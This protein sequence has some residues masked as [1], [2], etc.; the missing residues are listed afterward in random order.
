MTL[1]IRGTRWKG[2]SM[3]EGHLFPSPNAVCD[4]GDLDCGN[5]LLL[6]IRKAIDPLEPGQVLEVRSRE[7]SVEGDLPA[8]CRMVAHDFL[9][10]A[11]GSRY[12]SYFIRKGGA[13]QRP[14]AG[15]RAPT[16]KQAALTAA[17]NLGDGEEKIG[18]SAADGLEGTL[19]ED[20]EKARRFTWAVRAR[21]VDK[22]QSRVYARGQSFTVG[23]PIDFDFSKPDAPLSAVEYLLASLAACLTSGYQVHASRRGVTV[24]EAELA[25]RGGLNNPLIYLGLEGEGHSGFSEINGTFYVNADG[26]EDTLTELWETTLARSPIVA[27]L[28]NQVKLNLRFS[29]VL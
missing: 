7:P 11:P 24:Y 9:G 14:G 8:W 26:D 2:D 21:G 29:V 19:D 12:T 20:L 17:S 4:G 25:L 28:R 5:G 16:A 15:A 6:I 22:G 27:T 13:A 10:S 23:Q 18:S 3:A 1:L